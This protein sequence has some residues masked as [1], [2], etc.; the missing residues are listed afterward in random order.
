MNSKH[1]ATLTWFL[2]EGE[3]SDRLI[4]EPKGSNAISRHERHGVI[5]GPAR[6][7]VPLHELQ[8]LDGYVREFAWRHNNRPRR[9]HCS[10]IGHGQRYAWQDEADLV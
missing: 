6:A 5:P 9:Y 3:G 7:W 1:H 8:A 4:E 2:R 10:T